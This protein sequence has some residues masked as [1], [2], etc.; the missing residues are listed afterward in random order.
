M[1]HKQALQEY[2][3]QHG[4]CRARSIPFQITFA[5]WCEWWQATGL[6]DQR[7]R[8]HD[9][10]AM[11]RLDA[12]G[13]FSTDN[14]KCVTNRQAAEQFWTSSRRG[15]ALQHNR[16]ISQARSRPI[17]TPQGQFASVQAAAQHLKMS[18]SG[19]RWRIQHDTQAY[20]YI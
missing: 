10:Y 6:Y 14:I 4:N 16:Q 8:G 9:Q 11:V 18:T 3:T 17:Q 15:A 12:A 5:E 19:V 20:Y 13:A 1:D 7:G 2:R